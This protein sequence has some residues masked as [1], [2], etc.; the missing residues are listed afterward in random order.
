ME[1][2]LIRYSHPKISIYFDK[3][4]CWTIRLLNNDICY[5]IVDLYSHSISANDINI[6]F[7]FLNG[8][9]FLFYL[10][11]RNMLNDIKFQTQFSPNILDSFCLVKINL[12]TPAQYH[13]HSSL[14]TVMYAILLN[15]PEQY[16]TNALDT[17]SWYYYSYPKLYNIYN[18]FFTYDLLDYYLSIAGFCPINELLLIK[19]TNIKNKE[20][21]ISEFDIVL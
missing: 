3:Y 13:S 18:S 21:E 16:N 19:D 12:Q 11:S 9:Q 2:Q 14:Y 8:E 10:F 5:S 7:N 1:P 6:N 20:E 15:H 17:K 4:A